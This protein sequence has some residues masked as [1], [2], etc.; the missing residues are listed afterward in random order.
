MLGQDS[1][2]QATME[3]RRRKINKYAIHLRKKKNTAIYNSINNGYKVHKSIRVKR[4]DEMN[5]IVQW[6]LTVVIISMC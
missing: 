2:T 6:R 3:S 4:V 5:Y 1:Q